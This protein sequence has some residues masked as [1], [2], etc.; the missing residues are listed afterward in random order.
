[1]VATIQEDCIVADMDENFGEELRSAIGDFVRVARAATD[2]ASVS[3][4]ETLGLLSREG[5]LSVAELARRRG[6]RH[7]S[8]SATVTE[9]REAGLADRVPDPDDGRGWLITTTAEGERLIASNRAARAQWIAAATAN[10]D[11][12]E[13]AALAR[14]PGVLRKLA[15]T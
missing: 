14:I 2:T 10:L 1:M 5:T 15:E 12:D 3:L 9:L 7:Q 4:T 8:Q 11:D 13:R 6:V